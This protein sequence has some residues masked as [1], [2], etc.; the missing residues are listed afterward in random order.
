[1]RRIGVGDRVRAGWLLG[2]GLLLMGL[3]IAG[4]SEKQGASESSGKPP[5]A[6]GAPAIGPTATGP[7]PEQKSGNGHS[8]G[9]GAAPHADDEA[10][11]PV[12]TL[13]AI[14][15]AN[16]G[17]RI[18]PAE[19][20]AFED[21]RR[22][23][24]VM[25]A[26]PDLVAFVTSRTPGKVVA[27]HAALGARVKRGADV[28]EVQSAEVEK[29][30][31][32]LLQAENRLR[33]AQADADRTRGLVE[34]GIGARKDLIAAE[35]QLEGVKNE[36][37]GLIRQLQLL[38]VP[39]EGIAQVRRERA[40]TILHIAAPIDGIVVERPVVV[41]QAVEPTTPLLKLV[42]TSILIAQ[43]AAPED[44]LRELRVGQPVRV[45]VSA[46]PDKRFEGRLTFIHPQ[47]DPERRVAHVWAEVRNPGGELKEDMFAQLLVVVGG[48]AKTLVIP[49][50]ALMSEGGLEF[51]FTETPAGFKRT[52]VL[53]GA[54]NDQHVEIKQ[55]LTPGAK[56][57]TDGKRQVYTVFLTARS[58]AP[59]LSGH[60]H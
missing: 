3:V 36:I 13:T 27:I 47:I 10:A 54:R 30:E 55:G 18:E 11:G 57:I 22:L 60:T 21:V 16:V 46:Y 53:V 37:E 48:G 12:V 28:I 38:G 29:L 20:R 2:A 33:L 19:V 39:S 25:K 7:R 45:T 50:A 52:A 4:C 26:S 8:H 51:V 40:V 42:D 58:G 23:P 41:G 17:L 6:A 14:E 49:A 15:R 24:G 9:E 43:G 31:T 44:L 1:M 34:K 32:D 59:A 35:N 56:V 5:A